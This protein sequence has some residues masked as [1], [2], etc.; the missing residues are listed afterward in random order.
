MPKVN[1]AVINCSNSTYKLKKWKQV[2]YE[3][4]GFDSS[5]K[6]EDYIHC[7]PPFKLYCFPSILRN[8]ELRNKWIRALKRQNKDKTEWKPSENDRVCSI[9]FV[10]S[11]YEA[12]SVPTLNLGYEVEE[13]KARRTL[14]RQPLPKKSKIKQNNDVDDED[15]VVPLPISTTVTESQPTVTCSTPHSWS[16]TP[17]AS[18]DHSY[19]INEENMP[20]PSY[21]DLPDE[22]E[23]L[24][25]EN[26]ILKDKIKASKRPVKS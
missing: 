10:G 1:C 25:I 21:S 14:I 8:A 17:L 9:H 22:I 15:D 23:A 24:K 16:A 6:R 12:N 20:F 7:I 5:C 4:N 11:A 26:N 19:C 18:L 2:C 3:H 13:K